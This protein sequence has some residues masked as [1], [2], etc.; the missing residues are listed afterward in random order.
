MLKKRLV[1][2]GFVAFDP[3]ELGLA[4][5]FLGHSVVC[6]I[7]AIFTRIFVPETRDK[8]LSELCS[9]YK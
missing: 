1:C 8:T 9:V 3:Q 4:A 2:L 7:M 6:L 5:L